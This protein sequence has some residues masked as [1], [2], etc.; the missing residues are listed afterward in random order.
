MRG[1]VTRMKHSK[2]PW[3]LSEIVWTDGLIRIIEKESSHYADPKTFY[4]QQRR[5][6][7]S[8]VWWDYRKN[9]YDEPFDSL[10]E[11]IIYVTKK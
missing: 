11:A 2:G 1:K 6:E 9:E 7:H 3:P 5:Y 4:I 10:E 8:D